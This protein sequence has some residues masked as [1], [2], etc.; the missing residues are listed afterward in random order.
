MTT[1]LEHNLGETRYEIYSDDVLAGYADYDERNGMRDFNHT[2][3]V[4]EFRGKGIAAQV[5]EFALT[6]TRADGFKVV[7]SCWYVEK[8][9]AANS[10]YADL[11]A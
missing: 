10:E 7:P 3:T 5:V 9:I 8:Y 2:L 4:P 1:R 6:S 11:L